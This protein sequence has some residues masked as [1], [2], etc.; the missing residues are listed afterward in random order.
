MINY[1]KPVFTEKM[2]KTGDLI[3]YKTSGVSFI[4]NSFRLSI[5]QEKMRHFRHWC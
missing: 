1:D 2:S 3:A 5:F 4:L